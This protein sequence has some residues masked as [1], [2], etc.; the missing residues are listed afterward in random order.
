LIKN[1]EDPY[2]PAE[3]FVSVSEAEDYFCNSVIGLVARNKIKMPNQFIAFDTRYTAQF[4]D[5]FVSWNLDIS[6]FRRSI[7]VKNIDDPYAPEQKF[8]SVS[9][10]VKFFDNKSVEAVV[11]DDRPTIRQ[12]H[13][14]GIRYTAKYEDDPKQLTCDIVKDAR[15]KPILVKNLEDSYFPIQRFEGITE[16]IAVFGTGCIQD[17]VSISRKTKQFF[18][19]GTRYTAKY[20]TDSKPF[21]TDIKAIRNAKSVLIKNI[22]DPYFPAMWFP[23]ATLAMNFFDV[24][25]VKDVLRPSSSTRQFF[26]FDTRY[27]AQYEQQFI[28]WDLNIPLPNFKKFKKLA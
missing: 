15:C 2:S 23:S 25:T 24:T 18:A 4:E 13:A 10:A 21:E 11:G 26:A 8:K 7:I 12:F 22:E 27:T 16:A 1:I 5:E 20:E 17:V 28:V 6:D 14:F 9:S 3:R 19:F